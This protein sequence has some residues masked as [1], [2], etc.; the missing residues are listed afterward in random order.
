MITFLTVANIITLVRIGLTPVIALLIIRQCWISAVVCFAGAMLTDFADGFI[1]RLMNQQTL[2]GAILD[3]AADKVLM[4]T[5]FILALMINMP[6]LSAWF[7]WF[8]LGK[9][10]ILLIGAALLMYGHYMPTVAPLLM[11]KMTMAAQ[12]GFIFWWLCAQAG[13][14]VFVSWS[15]FVITGLNVVLVL[16]YAR[17]YGA[18]LRK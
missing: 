14:C 5:F 2:V 7:C 11:G 6:Q 12:M 18:L 16:M 13:W 17:E 3:H 4:L 8:M 1:A 9:E 10:L 15:V